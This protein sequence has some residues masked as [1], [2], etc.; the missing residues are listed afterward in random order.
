MTDWDARWAE[1]AA[2]IS[3]WSKDRSTK[4]GSVIVGGGNQILTAGYNGFPR[5]VNDNIDTRYE[6]PVKYKYTEHAERN[7]IYNAARY[8]IPLAGTV[9]YIPYYPCTDCARGIIQAG[10]TTVVTLEML[11][12][13]KQEDLLSRWGDDFVISRI[14]LVEAGVDVRFVSPP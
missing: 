13:E 10:I 6:R 5:G 4:V 7:A 3:T 2:H 14:M 11:Q 9:M 1:L 12:G 8:G